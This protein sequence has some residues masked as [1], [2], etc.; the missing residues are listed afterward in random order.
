MRPAEF[1]VEAIIEAMRA[2]PTGNYNGSWTAPPPATNLV[3]RDL[4][5]WMAGMQGVANADGVV[6]S[7]AI[8]GAGTQASISGCPAACVITVQWDDSRAGADQGGT[9]RTIVTR[10]TI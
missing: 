1:P 5:F 9:T 2:N 10:T 3:T 7:P 8:I 4:N 6:T